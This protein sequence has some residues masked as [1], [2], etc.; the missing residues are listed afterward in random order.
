MV[1]DP[2]ARALRALARVALALWLVLP[3]VPLAIWSLAHGWRFPDLLPQEI[4]LR[5]WR[6][7]LSDSSG[8]LQSLWLTS[9]IAGMVTMLSVLIG[10]PAGRAL[11]VYRFRGR[12]LVLLLV[13]APTL[14][15]G[16][17]AAFGLH[18]VFIALG[19][20][21]S[22]A[23]VV[24]VH[25]VPA[26]PYMVLVM[27]G[28]F[29]NHDVGLEQQARCLGAR[30]AQ[31]LWHVTLPAVLPGIVVGAMFT[32]LV[33]WSQYALTLVIGGGRV[34]TLPLL[35]FGFAS[36]GRHDLVGAMSMIYILPGAFVVLLTARRITGRPAALDGLARP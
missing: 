8:V 11:G 18:T 31:V 21:N 34:V 24:L 9:A 26:L 23:G 32:F 14:V 20:T 30:P 16:L 7:V 6:Y 28:I 33:S 22:L 13:L 29:A 10:V 15:P 1:P 35:L 2:R 17:A 4:S 36:S 12:G 5:A 25:L 3:L 27:T 19:L